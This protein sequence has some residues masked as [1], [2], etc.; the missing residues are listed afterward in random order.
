MGREL[1]FYGVDSER[2]S[3]VLAQEFRDKKV[4]EVWATFDVVAN[5]GLLEKIAL[6]P[7]ELTPAD[8]DKIVWSYVHW[9]ENNVGWDYDERFG[10]A[11][12][13]GDAAAFFYRDQT[14]LRGFHGL[15][16]GSV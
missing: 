2:L 12:K 15:R 4:L 1:Y 10:W 14:L 9:H 11:R 5:A 16:L 13:V 8:F 7:R 3:S 6:R